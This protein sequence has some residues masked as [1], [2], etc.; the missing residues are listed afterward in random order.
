MRERFGVRWWKISLLWVSLP[1]LNSLLQGW[2]CSIFFS[3]KGWQIWILVPAA[4]CWSLWKDRILGCLIIMQSFSIRFIWEQRIWCYF[5]Q[6]IANGV[7]M[8]DLGFLGGAF[9]LNKRKLKNEG[10][11]ISPEEPT[12]TRLLVAF[13]LVGL[14]PLYLSI[15]SFGLL[16]MS[17]PLLLLFFSLF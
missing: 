9:F 12:T 7:R 14:V 11:K 2:R 10:D 4:I 3:A 5:G 17:Y 15:L 1:E 16:W 8:W 13:L 6:S